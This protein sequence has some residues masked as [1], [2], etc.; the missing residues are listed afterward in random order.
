MLNLK[1]LQNKMTKIKELRRNQKILILLIFAILV[2][3][4]YQ[5]LI[6]IQGTVVD[7]IDSDIRQVSVMSIRDLSLN[8]DPLPLLGE[9]QS[10]SSATIYSQ[11]SGEVIGLYKKLGDFVYVDQVIAE[12][13]NWSQR[14]AVTQAKA[15]VEVAQASLD[16][17]KK[18]GRD[19][20]LSILKTT[21]DN[22]QKT[23]NET[24]IS[25]I[26]VLNDTFV[27]IDDSVR[28]KID[29]M[30]RN[31]REDNP[32][33]LFSVYSSQLEIDIEWGRFLIEKMLDNWDVELDTL[34]AG[35][36]LIEKLDKASSDVDSIRIFLNNLALA[37][38]DLAPNSNLSETTINTWKANISLVR[39]TIN[40]AVSTLSA[41]KSGLN[42]TESALE[43]A[44]LNYDQ[45]EAGGRS[46][47]VII[48]EAQ[49]KQAEAGLQSAYAS[50][51][52]TIIRA[53]ISGTINSLELES[54]DFVSAF[55]PVVTLANNKTLEI[56][57]YIT[58]EDRNDIKVGSTVAIGSNWQGVIKNIAPSLDPQTKKIKVEISVADSEISLTNGQSV[59]LLLQRSSSEGQVI[60]DFSVPISAIKI[61]ADRTVVYTIDRENKLV[62]H[63]V[64]L[65][66]IL[67]GKII[68]SE[69]VSVDMKI[70]TDA[71]GLQ[72]GQAVEVVK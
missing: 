10:Q 54:G 36:D 12:I 33:V 47:D 42:N 62:A 40:L 49:L 56:I 66:S 26:N 67:G 39:T 48:A 63:P 46:E 38:N 9:V 64:V 17:I 60:V 34:S 32:Q 15:N 51:E 24:K 7:G 45:A 3:V 31:P 19:E 22:S 71:R 1:T 61:G 25:A 44:Q 23:L 50:L 72:E 58:E 6:I 21:L 16:K 30:F 57:T 69:G 27:K 14:S 43:I 8:N 35:S 53:P 4:F 55:I 37:V 11:T 59:S 29:I 52:K 68:I 28:N 2:V 41:T 5:Q 70:I 65:G 13:N 20:Q 18:G